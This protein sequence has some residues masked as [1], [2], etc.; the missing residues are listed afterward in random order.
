MKNRTLENGSYCDHWET[1]DWLKAEIVK[2]FGEYFDP[3]PLHA[4]F[5]GLE[6]CWGKVNYVNPPYNTKDKKAFIE[7]ALS[8]WLA[9]GNKSIVLVPATTEV[10]WFHESVVPF[11][12]VRLL[13]KR[14]S[15]KG[16]D[17]KGNIAHDH[18]TGQTGSMLIIFG[19][20]P[21]IIAYDYGVR[22]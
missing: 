13:K 10:K 19:N 5:N 6:I 2:E 9:H 4:T 17:S 11:A 20:D 15:F 1:P 21:K 18:K 7:H 14:I 22:K 16:F 8:E 12:E 3:C